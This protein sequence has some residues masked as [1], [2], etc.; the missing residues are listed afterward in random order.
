MLDLTWRVQPYRTSSR[1]LFSGTVSL[2]LASPPRIAGRCMLHAATWKA[3]FAG[4]GTG[5]LTDFALLG[6]HGLSTNE[7]EAGPSA[8]TTSL[9]VQS[10]LSPRSPPHTHSQ[11]RHYYC[12]HSLPSTTSIINA[13]R[14]TIRLEQLTTQCDTTPPRLHTFV[15]R[16]RLYGHL[17]H[18]VSGQ[19][20]PC[21]TSKYSWRAVAI[22]RSRGSVPTR[23]CLC[24]GRKR[25]RFAESAWSGERKR[26]TP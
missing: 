11:P 26:W 19:R 7:R 22:V 23:V 13:V 21:C 25:D 20:H 1:G 16:G 8:G 10:S 12:F 6:K 17:A 4:R 15:H 9:C 14:A 5:A 24:F 3:L 18:S 2:L